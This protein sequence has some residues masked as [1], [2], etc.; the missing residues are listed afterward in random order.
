LNHY[1][2]DLESM[3]GLAVGYAS[4][5]MI[6]E[7]M[8]YVKMAVQN[9]L[10]VERFLAGPRNLIGPLLESARFRE[11]IQ[12]RYDRLVHGPMLGKVTDSGAAVWVRTSQPAE[13][14]VR[15]F[16]KGEQ[17]QVKHFTGHTSVSRDFTGIVGLSNLKPKK[18][19]HYDVYVDGSR[20][21]SGGTFRTYPEAGSPIQ[22][23]IGFGG[24]AGYTPW[25]EQ[26]W[27]TLSTH[28]FDA[29]LH[30]GDNVYIDHPKH[31]ET[32]R[33]NYYR[34]QSRPEFRRFVSNTSNYAIWDDHDFTINDG[35]GSPQPETPAGNC[36][37]I[38]GTI[39][40]MGEARS[41]RESGLM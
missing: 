13:V 26:I 23:T 36:S 32:Q 1:P 14:E 18:T 39:P 4:L 22:T 15:A 24:G 10:P 25:F 37:P 29:F 6:P 9:G 20:Y 34:R 27:D 16:E 28:R 38:S 33:Y 8:R 40:I 11:F 41:I 30:M 2:E 3:Y 31:P 5:E 7:A 19:Y 35:N 12:G 17:D 21:F